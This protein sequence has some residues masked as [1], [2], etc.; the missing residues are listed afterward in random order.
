[1]SP[2]IQEFIDLVETGKLQASKE[3]H[4]LIDHIKYC[5]ETEDIYTDD[6]QL[7]KYLGI[8]KYFPWDEGVLPWQKFVLA[9][10]TCTYWRTCPDD[11]DLEGEP[12]WPDLFCLIGRGAGKTGFIGFSAVCLASQYNKRVGREYDVDVVAN[13]E[14][15][16]LMSVNDIRD[17]FEQPKVEEKLR[18][19]YFEWTKEVVVALLTGAEIRGRTNNPKS[20]DGLRSGAVLFD[21]VHGYQNYENID[22]FTTGMGKKKHPRRGFFSS[23]GF[24]RNGPLDDYIEKSNKILFEDEPDYGWLPFICKLDDKDEVD[25][26][27]MWEKA[28]PSLPFS[29]TLRLKI[30]QE[31]R[32]WKAA[33][34]KAPSFLTKRFGIYDG[35]KEFMVTTYENIQY[36]NRPIPDLTKWK[37]V[38]GIDFSKTTDWV[39]AT[40]HFRNG[41]LRYDI[42]H[43]WVCDSENNVDLPL[44]KAP[45]H[46]W[47]EMGLIT[48]VKDKSINPRVVATWLKEQSQFYKIVKIALDS[49]R[50]V[51][52]SDALNNAGFSQKMIFEVRPSNI[53]K[54]QPVIDLCFANQYFVWGDNPCLRWA[55]NNTKLVPA[56]KEYGGEVGNFVYG[57]ISPRNR[58][59]DPFFSLV[60]AMC[61]EDELQGTAPRQGIPKA[62]TIVF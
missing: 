8:A 29:K 15:Q 42:N 61:I 9:L 48:F 23:N 22:V 33:P 41:D 49:Y 36:T 44:I 20:K 55:V 14:S 53:M 27:Q 39:S 25:D 56:K 21:E 62:I 40:L 1:M 28:N 4:A 59:T 34:S 60:S 7:E 37:C 11:P 5:F 26:P 45:I 52:L 30:R 2:Y 43:T 3:V 50:Y 31:Y 16:A 12:R 58:K 32:D 46:D 18:G 17:A 13:T 24:V 35:I 19:K 47:E 10:W 57:K 54:I 6:E 38:A 51:V